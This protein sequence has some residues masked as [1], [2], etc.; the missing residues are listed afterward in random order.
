MKTS[1][2]S[3]PNAGMNTVFLNYLHSRP[4]LLLYHP[5]M[6]QEKFSVT[7]SG[8]RKFFLA[9]LFPYPFFSTSRIRLQWPV[10]YQTKEIR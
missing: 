8:T 1:L 2:I 4:K 7:S 9:H 5:P 3:T 10:R 6:R